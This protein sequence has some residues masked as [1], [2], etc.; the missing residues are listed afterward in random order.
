MAA[1]G[2]INV[3]VAVLAVRLIVLVAICGGILL[4]WFAL[5]NPDPMRLWA[6]GIYCG[7]VALPAS[8]L[9]IWWR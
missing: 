8:V 6:L 3:L 1:M 5:Q 4:T 9:A 7:I 2:T